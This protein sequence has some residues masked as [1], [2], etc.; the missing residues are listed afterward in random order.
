MGKRTKQNKNVLLGIYTLLFVVLQFI[1]VPTM[2]RN[3]TI[4]LQNRELRTQP[5]Q[6]NKYL[7]LDETSILC[8][9]L[10]VFQAKKLEF[11]HHQCSM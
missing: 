11:Y 6:S 2:V 3:D 4:K 10:V 8:L 7:L 9:S 5:F 1:R